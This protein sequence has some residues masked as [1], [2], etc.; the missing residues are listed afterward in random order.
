MSNFL[1]FRRRWIVPS[2][3][4]L[5]ALIAVVALISPPDKILGDRVRLVYVH[6]SIIRVVLALFALAGL[7]GLVYLPTNRSSW[8]IWS[9]AFEQASLIMWFAYILISIVTTIAT[10]GGVPLFEPRWIFS[11]QISIIAPL[12]YLAGRVMK[13]SKVA[14]ALNT[15]VIAMIVF[16]ESRAELILHPIDPIGTSGNP[17]IQLAYLIILVL[18]ALVGV[19]VVNGLLGL[20]AD[21]MSDHD[22]YAAIGQI[23]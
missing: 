12:A 20:A 6:G 9:R 22:A 1:L 17:A 19:Q 4:V 21:R 23:R 7:T 11:I 16:L 5:L 2:L 18:W 3:I 15:G 10:W 8:F 14:A 13:N